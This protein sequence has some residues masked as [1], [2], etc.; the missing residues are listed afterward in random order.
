MNVFAPRFGRKKPLFSYYAL[1]GCLCLMVAA[2]TFI[3]D[4]PNA[5]EVDIL[6]TVL[7][8]F[9]RFWLAGAFAVIYVYS[10]ELFPTVIRNTAFGVCIC[11][12]TFGGVMAP[13]ILLLVSK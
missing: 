7:V 12:H 11:A 1:S 6:R 9:A 10:S 13:Q 2:L 3:A 4:H 5:F 8:L